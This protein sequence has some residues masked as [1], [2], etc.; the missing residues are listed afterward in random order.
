MPARL[1]PP[2][3]PARRCC[4]SHA[5]RP[6]AHPRVLQPV[7]GQGGGLHHELN[8]G[9]GAQA[10]CCTA[11]C[12]GAQPPRA[13]TCSS[14]PETHRVL[15][16]LCALQDVDWIMV[17][18]VQ[19]TATRRRLQQAPGAAIPGRVQVL[20]KV[21]GYDDTLGAFAQRSQHRQLRWGLDRLSATA[22]TSCPCCPA[23]LSPAHTRCHPTAPAC[24]QARSR[25]L[26][27][28]QSTRAPSSASC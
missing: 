20:T 26:S 3:R 14:Y 28:K 18:G 5:R 2:H 22:P 12:W 4:C 27:S 21:H 16:V 19:A 7:Q 17:N 23:A 13:C 11:G 10:G 24:P 6:P 15:R 1:P 8:H 25:G 9:P